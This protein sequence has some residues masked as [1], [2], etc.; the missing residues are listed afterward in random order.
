[1]VDSSPK[2]ALNIYLSSS[3]KYRKSFSSYAIFPDSL[4]IYS[5]EP[6]LLIIIIAYSAIEPLLEEP[7]SKSNSELFCILKKLC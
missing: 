7:I 3:L 4:S 5:L 1:M 2:Y 6:S